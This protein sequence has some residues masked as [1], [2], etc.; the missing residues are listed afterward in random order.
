[1]VAGEDEE[2]RKNRDVILRGAIEKRYLRLKVALRE[3]RVR[4]SASR[5]RYYAV[6]PS[7]IDGSTP[8]AHRR[9]EWGK[10]KKK[11][12]PRVAQNP[13]SSRTRLRDDQNRRQLVCV[14]RYFDL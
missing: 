14:L 5:W 6:A 7:P 13:S 3:T 10:Y 4:L 9:R 11:N 2:R 1:M 8:I 12:G